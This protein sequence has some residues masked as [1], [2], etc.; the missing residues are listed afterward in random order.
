[1]KRKVQ[2][3]KNYR[4]CSVIKKEDTYSIP[5]L[6]RAEETP[7]SKKKFT[8]EKNDHKKRRGQHQD[9]TKPIKLGN[10]K[11]GWSRNKQKKLFKREE[12]S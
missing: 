4:T 1:M 3:K 5:A 2:G 6:T 8:K 7:S 9:E 12:H 11:K 10:R